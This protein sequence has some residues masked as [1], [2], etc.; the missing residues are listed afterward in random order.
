MVAVVIENNISYKS[1]LVVDFFPVFAEFLRISW[2]HGP[3]SWLPGGGA[4]FS[5]LVNVLESLHISLIYL[6]QSQVFIYISS[7]WQIVDAQVSHN[8]FVIHD[9]SSSVT[10][11]GIIEDSVGITDFLPHVG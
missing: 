11:S 1:F 4:N 5:V 7:H 9:E 3:L 8:L 2:G 10:D 6:H